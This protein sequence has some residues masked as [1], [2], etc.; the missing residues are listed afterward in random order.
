MAN[1]TFTLRGRQM[2]SLDSSSGNLIGILYETNETE[3]NRVLNKF[4]SSYAEEENGKYYVYHS[5]YLKDA[6]GN[7]KLAPHP[8]AYETDNGNVDL[9]A[10]LYNNKSIKE[11]VTKSSLPNTT[12][13][14]PNQPGTPGTS[15]PGT[16][17]ETQSNNQRQVQALTYP[18]DMKPDQDKIKF[19]AVE[20]QPRTQSGQGLQ[21]N[22]GSPTYKPVGGGPVVLAI[23]SPISDQNSVDWGPDSV[24][25]IDAALYKLSYGAME[26]K[27]GQQAKQALEQA[28]TDFVNTLYSYQGRIQRY[29]A[30]Q[31][32]SIN[33]ILARTDNVVLNPNLELLFQGPQLRPFSFTFKLSPR[34]K[35]E[36]TEVRKII[37]YF[38]QNMAVRA[39]DGLFLKAPYVFTIQ[40]FKGSELHKSIGRISESPTQKA[41]AL[42]NCSV[43]YTPLG[44]Y[45]TYNDKAGTMVSYTLSLQFQE[46]TPIYDTD[47]KDIPE[48]D[49]GY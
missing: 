7:W 24:N 4:G 2:R 14:D 45:M 16:P 15:T 12:P 48:D 20:I 35:G 10:D 49:I 36:A 21:F 43:D 18:S 9:Y 31:A 27:S 23:Q 46:L 26:N 25:A 33:N 17:N 3:Y 38:K 13:V 39:E 37:R 28:G 40:Y 19:Q 47:Y 42:T 11:Q 22:F 34:N 8:P 1:T 32:A 29:L 6:Q 41:C 30:G 5:A 44:T